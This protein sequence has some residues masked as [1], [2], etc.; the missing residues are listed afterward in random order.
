[1]SDPHLPLRDDIQRLGR[2]LG[3]RLRITEGDAL[4][5]TV[6]RVRALSKDAHG[7]AGDRAFEELAAY[8]DEQPIARALPV[9][10]AFSQF[11]N[12]ANIAEQ[13]HRIRRRRDYQ[14]NP[15]AGPQRGSF[16]EA[17]ARLIAQG[18]APE[19]LHAAVSD[20]RVELV[21]TAHPTEIMRRSLIQ[22]HARVADL[23]A[24][25][26]RTDLTPS[27]R[28][29]IEDA[30]RREVAILWSTSE[31]RAERPSPL[32]EVRWGLAVIDQ[33]LWYAVPDTLRAL[34][35]ALERHTGL[36]LPDSAQPVRFGSWIGGDRDG[37][38]NVTPEVTR[39]A[40][41]MARWVAADLLLRDVR[42]LATELS[43][44]HGTPELHEAAGSATEPYRA[45]LRQL[46]RRLALTRER[47]EAALES[48]ATRI[49]ATPLGGVRPL[50]D[51]AELLE[52]LDACRRSLVGTRNE[53]VA[54]GRLLD[55]IRRV[56]VFGLAL[57]PLDIRQEARVHAETIEES[58]GGGY[59]RLDEEGRQR[60]LV[61]RLGGEVREQGTTADE[62]FRT[63]ASLHRDSLGAYVITMASEPSDVLAVEYL[64]RIAGIATPLRVVPLF[65][66]AGDLQRAGRT[67][68]TLFR[69]PWYRAR[70]AA[71]GDRQEVMVGYSDS[72]KDAGRFA[73]AWDLYQAQEA[74]VSACRAHG[75]R[76][77]LFH[78]RGGS[79][80]RGGGPTHLA[81][82]SQPAGSIDGTLRVT[83]QGEMLQAKFGLVGI[84]ARTL[85]VYVTSALEAT[86]APRPE[87]LREHRDEMQRLA[88]R[89]REAF[90]ELIGRV[91]FKEY[92]RAATPERE[93]DLTN[94]GSRPARRAG[95]PAGLDGLRAIPWQFAWTQTR[96]L[97]SSWLG[98][99]DAF[100]PS[101]PPRDR[102]MWRRMYSDW[103]FF[104]ST[105]D[106]IE[107]VL[108]KADRRIAGEYDR[109]LVPARLQP[110]GED[111][112]GRLDAAIAAV[113]EVTGHHTL[114]EDNRVLRR[115]IAVRNPYVDPINLVQIELLL[116][117]RADDTRQEDLERAFVA[118]VNGIS[119][120]MRNTG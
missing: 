39:R 20:M 92:F 44:Q 46:R 91:E 36:R 96:L 6:E 95:T 27:E 76:L 110:I 8:L 117:L 94:I 56:R 80:G 77:T 47:A 37:N 68:D 120:G 107:M 10:R 15:Q 40:T 19:R 33:R 45:V 62:L 14:K 74:I 50:V 88:D 104:R 18:V 87:P 114:L 98:V 21:F 103:P 72:S 102:D 64:Q 101:A 86:V 75:V 49:E 41:L 58:S 84:A 12:L 17:F 32:D 28:V 99:E 38:P 83:E 63:M 5:E 43:L 71:N 116:R 108:A 53:I 3:E 111:L 60:W 65:E 54:D 97:L 4:F 23:L 24:A 57:V 29:A 9:A 25:D 112:R 90:R 79:V 67:L 35:A 52:V 13:H 106:L 59:R 66:T 93:L 7:P 69:V 113:L 22:S 51:P 78:G 11:L 85:E 34:D 30:L 100:T 55:I 81:I 82:Q 89:S 115:S 26:D 118:T 31:V 2:L 119:A 1:V 70:V 16:D 42:R 109:R 61:E 105:V 48:G 73:A